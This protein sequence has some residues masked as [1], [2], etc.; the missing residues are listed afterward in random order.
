MTNLPFSRP[1][2][3]ADLPPAVDPAQRQVQ[4]HPE[5]TDWNSAY[6]L[7]GNMQGRNALVLLDAQSSKTKIH[8]FPE[9]KSQLFLDVPSSLPSGGVPFYGTSLLVMDY[10]KV[11]D[12]FLKG[13]QGI[14]FAETPA[15]EYTL[16]SFQ[17]SVFSQTLLTDNDLLAQAYVNENAG[18]FILQQINKVNPAAWAAKAVAG[19]DVGEIQV[20]YLWLPNVQVTPPSKGAKAPP[21]PPPQSNCMVVC[22]DHGG[23]CVSDSGSTMYDSF[24]KPGQK[25]YQI[26]CKNG[27]VFES[28]GNKDATGRLI[29]AYAGNLSGLGSEQTQAR[30]SSRPPPSGSASGSMSSFLPNAGSPKLGALGKFRFRYET[31]QSGDTL[32]TFCSRNGLTRQQFFELNPTKPRLSLG[33]DEYTTLLQE[34]EECLVEV[35]F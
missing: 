7:L 28:F 34:Q 1:L 15:G 4:A 35:L 3:P 32:G 10:L 16:R 19:A 21:P 9:G 20:Q 14:A 5:F 26:V 18:A 23:G 2:T 13:N 33:G 22:K 17:A 25:A 30:G 6:N 12:Y 11:R 27:F 31:V 24:L 8:G 29:F